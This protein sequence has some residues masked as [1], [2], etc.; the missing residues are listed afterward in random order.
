MQ[1]R[2]HFL[3]YRLEAAAV[4]AEQDLTTGFQL[5]VDYDEN[6]E[7]PVTIGLANWLRDILSPARLLKIDDQ[8]T[9]RPDPTSAVDFLMG[10][11]KVPPRAR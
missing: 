2:E 6:T 8:P 11:S 10:W 1:L 4:G 3:R 7:Y 9:A 5:V